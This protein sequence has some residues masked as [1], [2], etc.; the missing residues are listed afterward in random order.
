MFCVSEAKKNFRWAENLRTFVNYK[1]NEN[2]NQH[3]HAISIYRNIIYPR[4][5][6]IL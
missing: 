3:V 5:Y 4:N 6:N 1:F 2:K